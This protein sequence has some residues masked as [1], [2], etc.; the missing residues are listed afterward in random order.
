[1]RISQRN[2]LLA[3]HG[4]SRAFL[5][6]P[7]ADFLNHDINVTVTCVVWREQLFRPR[8]L[9]GSFANKETQACSHSRGEDSHQDG[10]KLRVS[11]AF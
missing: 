2:K 1:V 8:S 4:S 5:E 11:S 10:G 6:T 3:N 7:A 9:D